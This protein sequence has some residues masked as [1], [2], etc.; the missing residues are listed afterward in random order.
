MTRAE[1]AQY[2]R[3][4]LTASHVDADQLFAPPA[5][6]SVFTATDGVPRLVNQVC[7]RALVLA[8]ARRLERIDAGV[9]SSGVGR[10]AAVAD[11]VGTRQSSRRLDRRAPRT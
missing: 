4:Q 3:A 5:F 7:D 2:I 8:D 11:C 10:F 6:D 9:D 1:T